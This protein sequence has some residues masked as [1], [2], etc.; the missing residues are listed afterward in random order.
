MT[1]IEKRRVVV[2]RKTRKTRHNNQGR[3]F[4]PTGHW[5]RYKKE[6][7]SFYMVDP[8]T[9]KADGPGFKSLGGLFA[10]FCAAARKVTA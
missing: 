8:A 10:A 4:A 2:R 6:G 5:A 3:M 7:G 9:K 1:H